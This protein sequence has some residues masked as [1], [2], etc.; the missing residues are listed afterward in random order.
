MKIT[1]TYWKTPSTAKWKPLTTYIFNSDV[2]I[3]SPSILK[4][5]HMSSNFLASYYLHMHFLTSCSSYMPHPFHPLSFDHP[6]T[7]NKK[8]TKPI[9]M[10]FSLVPVTSSPFSPNTLF[11]TLFSNN[12]NHFFT[13][14]VFI[15]MIFKCLSHIL[16]GWNKPMWIW[17]DIDCVSC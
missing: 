14:D 9:L 8:N 13:H 12:L 17:Y 5:S 3:N 15:T 1:T 10:K 2:H 11:S 16:L 7:F 6:I 4:I